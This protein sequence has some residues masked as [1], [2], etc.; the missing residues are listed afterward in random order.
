MKTVFSLSFF[1]C[2]LC[3][4]CTSSDGGIIF[5]DNKTTEEEDIDQ[6][7]FEQEDSEDI[8]IVPD[9]DIT[10]IVDCT[11]G[12]TAECY[13]GPS[14]TK[15][16]GICKSGVSTCNYDGTA[17]SNC[18]GAIL[19]QAEI[20]GDGID[21][22]CDGADADSGSA[23]DIDGDGF[24]YC[25]GDCCETANECPDPVKV[26]PDAFEIPG[27]SV[28]DNC[29]GQMDEDEAACDSGLNSASTDP[30]D[31]AKAM[32]ICPVENGKPFGLLTADLLFPDGSSSGVPKAA[33]A[34]FNSFGSSITP[35]KGSNF[36]A[37]SS[38]RTTNPFPTTDQDNQTQSNAPAD[39]YSAN[40]NNFPS[41]PDCGASG[42]PGGNPCFDPVMLKLKLKAPLNAASFS[43]D[44]YF[45]SK[46]F[47]EYV[48]EYNDFFITLIDSAFYDPDPLFQNPYD[49]NLAM[50]SNKNPVGI[51][52]AMSGLF[53][54]CSKST[55]K[56]V[57][58]QYCNGEDEL[59]GTGFEGHGATGWLTTKGNI[60]PGEEFEL[61][62][63]IWD[64]RDHILDSLIII[65]NFRWN[66]Y[67]K[68]PGTGIGS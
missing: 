7:I 13:T 33:Y 51:N 48:C 4:S 9:L 40:G 47:P 64:T 18:D 31:M 15:G 66:P 39:W 30:A 53:T 25:T 24:T 67:K 1:I 38:G 32:D 61:R 50:D 28:D 17:W 62:F 8:D 12:E 16:V 68:N 10:V 43:F 57:V 55:S 3:F 60:I 36:Y 35:H 26:N 44:I 5:P 45:I 41:S 14:G 22:N 20:C 19:P 23:I 65:D 49:K 29:D 21:Q 42:N 6:D 52:L 27:N 34:I 46:E 11:P 63:A 37:M 56:P 2:I 54:V 58:T 59:K